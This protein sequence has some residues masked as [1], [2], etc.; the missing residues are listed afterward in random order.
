MSGIKGNERITE[1]DPDKSDLVEM[2]KE[3][4]YKVS[5]DFSKSDGLH[6]HEFIDPES[7][8]WATQIEFG[9]SKE[10]FLS[11]WFSDDDDS[12]PPFFVSGRADS[13]EW[14]R[15]KGKLDEL[16]PVV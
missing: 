15:L 11:V 7:G 13:D 1:A 2:F 10:Q 5:W 9:I 3:M 14:K 4:G 8:R 16:R 6:W 12:Y